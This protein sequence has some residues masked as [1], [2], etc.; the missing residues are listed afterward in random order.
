MRERHT[1][2]GAIINI[3]ST[4]G[5]QGSPG[6]IGYATAKAGLLNFTRATAMEL[7]PYKIRV[8]SLTPTG[9]PPI[10]GRQRA[11]RWGVAW[12]VPAGT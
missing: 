2:A 9:T 7:A 6:N 4:E 1:G 12:S 8:N 11:A 3:V 10:E 5:H